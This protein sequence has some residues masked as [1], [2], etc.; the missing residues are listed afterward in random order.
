[1]QARSGQATSLI[2]W[3]SVAQL[4]SWGSVFYLFALLLDP[5]ERDLGLRRDQTSLAFSLALL[6]EGLLA[7]PVGRLIERGHERAVMTGGSLVLAAGLLL[8]SVVSSQAGL[9]AVWLLL[10]A[11]LAATLYPPAFAV[12]IRRYPHNFRRAII[13]MTFLGGL[14]STVF[15]PLTAW[16]MATLGWRQALWPLAALHLL[17]CAPI[18]ALSLIHI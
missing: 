11:G 14:A 12:L 1:M 17:L 4:V 8:H 18:H 10:G 6:A 9:Y 2:G 15:M 7:W 3:L 16:L 5:V 13:V